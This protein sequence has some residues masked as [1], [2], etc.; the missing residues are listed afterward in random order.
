MRAFPA[1]KLFFK[2]TWP[3]DKDE[4]GRAQSKSDLATSKS[5]SHEHKIAETQQR[6][7]NAMN[8]T[9]DTQSIYILISGNLQLLSSAS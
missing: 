1:K 3:H 9:H 5:T 7:S 6:Q 4:N 8:E 2:K